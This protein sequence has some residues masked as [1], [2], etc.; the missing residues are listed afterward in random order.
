[1]KY[2]TVS[3]NNQLQEQPLQG[4]GRVLIVG[5]LQDALGQVLDNLIQASFPMKGWQVIF[6]EV[7]SNLGCSKVL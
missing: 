7:L 6:F 5:G 4:C 3:E 2:F 1:M